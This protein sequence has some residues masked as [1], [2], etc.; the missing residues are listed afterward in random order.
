MKHGVFSIVMWLF[1]RGY[2]TCSIIVFQ[3]FPAI[4]FCFVWSQDISRHSW[5][6]G[7]WLQ[8]WEEVFHHQWDI[9]QQQI[10]H[11]PFVLVKDIS[12][13]I[14]FEDISPFYTI[15]IYFTINICT[16]IY[17]DRWI[18]RYDISQPRGYSTCMVETFHIYICIDIIINIYIYIHIYIHTYIYIYIHTYTYIYIYTYIY[19][20][21]LAHQQT[22]SYVTMT[23]MGT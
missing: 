4:A 19:T 14:L 11:D 23:I 15:K 2:P 22:T 21:I 7:A 20:M 18:D 13:S 3:L 8:P 16:Y 12:P 17:I 6:R 9:H 5:Q 1:T 10:R